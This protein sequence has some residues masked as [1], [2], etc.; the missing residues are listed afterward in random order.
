MRFYR[1]ILP[2]V[3]LLAGIPSAF[4][5][6]SARGGVKIIEVKPSAGDATG[7]FAAAVERASR[8]NGAHVEIR[9][10]AGATYHIS[11]AKS[12][13]ALYHIS[14]TTSADENPDPVKHIGLLL[15][16]LRNVTFNGMGATIVT[17][18]EMTPWVVDS[19]ENVTLKN[20]T[21]T[22]ADPSVPEITVTEVGDSSL[23][24]SVHPFS[25]Y[26]ID[27]DG[28]L[29]WMGE[30]WEFTGGIAQQYSPKTLTTWRTDE[31]LA[32][33]VSIEETA[34]ATLKLVYHCGERPDTESGNVYQM[35]HSFRTEVAGF[36]NCSSDVRLDSLTL[37]FMGNFGIVAQN[38]RNL[39]YR[40]LTCAPDPDSGRTCCGF[41]DFLQISGCGGMISVTDSY[42]AGAHD[43]PINVHGTHMKVCDVAGNRLKVR[44][45]H[46]QTFG[47][48][49][50]SA[51]DSI[52]LVNADNLRAFA[53][54]RLV[55]ARMDGDYEMTL[56]TDREFTPEEIAV[57]CD[58][59][60]ENISWCPDVTIARNYF[61]LTPTRGIL[62]TTRGKSVIEDN[63]FF[64]I[65]MP[66]ILVADDARSWYESGPV[67]DL[68]IR[69]N[70]FI[71]CA[72]PVIS[73]SPEIHGERPSEEMPVHSGISVMSNS[74]ED[75]RGVPHVFMRAT[76]SSVVEGNVSAEPFAVWLENCQPIR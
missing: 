75:T 5:V 46:G 8:E 60:V 1:I 64:R 38:S 50:F 37:R 51:G 7:R 71:G 57:C 39:A 16:N 35:R 25:H 66:A 22:A 67:R 72:A 52:E 34:P 18:G 62:I 76:S 45:M 28:K 21:V 42:F 29:F 65:P 30:G 48:E 59:V 68:T 12:H 14:N 32:R 10:T 4:C 20:F 13:S 27:N 40:S 3:L 73:V 2:S 6:S 23:T 69:H 36:V 63:T 17:H 41:A 11:R 44:F 58:A 70:R 61:T 74:F 26:R 53:S 49:A 33:A 54:A 31:P 9:L 43:D 19:C 47:F 15:K 55:G 56:V 24:V